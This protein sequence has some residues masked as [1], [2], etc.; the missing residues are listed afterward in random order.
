M[1]FPK[2]NVCIWTKKELCLNRFIFHD[3]IFFGKLLKNYEEFVFMYIYRFSSKERQ[4]LYSVKT[5]DLSSILEIE[6]SNK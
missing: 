5:E 2:P 3:P 4:I 1:T 6:S